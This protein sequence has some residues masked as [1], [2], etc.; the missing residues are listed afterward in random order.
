MFTLLEFC[1]F[2]S[3]VLKALSLLFYRYLVPPSFIDVCHLPNDPIT[4]ETSQSACCPFQSSASSTQHHAA[5]T[6]G[7]RA[8]RLCVSVK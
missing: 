1:L 8:D 5:H 2:L 3:A 7:G 6:C 4:D